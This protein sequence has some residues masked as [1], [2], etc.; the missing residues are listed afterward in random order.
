MLRI[1]AWPFSTAFG[2]HNVL[3]A[4]AF[5]NLA[6]PA[7]DKLVADLTTCKYVMPSPSTLDME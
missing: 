6:R 4:R 1:W 5:S 3:K 2:L 7:L